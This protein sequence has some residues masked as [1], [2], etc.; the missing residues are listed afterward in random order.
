MNEE[1]RD[2]IGHVGQYEVSNFGRVRSIPRT[3]N[4]ADG[5]L[6]RYVGKMLVLQSDTKGYRQVSLLRKTRRVHVLVLEAFS[7]PRPIG[8]V[9]RHLNGDVNDNSIGNLAW[10]TPSENMYDT[11][12]HGSH[13][14]ARRTCCPRCGNAFDEAN[15]YVTTTGARKCRQCTRSALREYKRQQRAAS[16]KK[17]PKTH[18]INGHEFTPENT[19]T[20]S[21]PRGGR[22]CRKCQ[23]EANAR[24][25]Q[26]RKATLS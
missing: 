21:R 6:V 19:F 20:R 18:C 15:T 9:A 24:R 22:G 7:G 4:T 13:V 5:R 25:Y 2:V 17:A 8:M 12:R 23:S 16:P 3:R 14:Y 10:G 11:V 26:R 1:W